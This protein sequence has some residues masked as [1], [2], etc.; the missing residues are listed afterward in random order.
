MFNYNRT[1]HFYIPYSF[2]CN[3]FIFLLLYYPLNHV[4]PTSLR[5]SIVV[6][7]CLLFKN[8]RDSQVNILFYCIYLFIDIILLPMNGKPTESN[9]LMDSCSKS[10]IMSWRRSQLQ[11]ETIIPFEMNVNKSLIPNKVVSQLMLYIMKLNWIQMTKSTFCWNMENTSSFHSPIRV[12]FNM[13][14]IFTILI[15]PMISIV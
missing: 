1:L 6:L 4:I 7:P 11:T 5:L 15:V 12:I 13:F 14:M 2:D 9:S 8:Y 10:T 3:F